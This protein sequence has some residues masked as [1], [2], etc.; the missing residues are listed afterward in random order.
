MGGVWVYDKVPLRPGAGIVYRN[1]TVDI[2]RGVIYKDEAFGL[3]HLIDHGI[4]DI[5]LILIRIIAS[6]DMG[7][8]G[9]QIFD[10]FRRAADEALE[11]L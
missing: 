3:V 6:L 2:R 8:F 10:V 1:D 7:A 5:L 11:D 4:L 9:D